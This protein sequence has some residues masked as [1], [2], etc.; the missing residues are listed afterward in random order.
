MSNWETLRVQ[1]TLEIGAA[2][3]HSDNTD[4]PLELRASWAQV[5]NVKDRVLGT[6]DA[7]EKGELT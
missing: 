7:I 3:I 5:A 4:L 6:M 1:L 2:R